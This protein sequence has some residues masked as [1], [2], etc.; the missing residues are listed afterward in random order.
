MVARYGRYF[1]ILFKEY[2]GI[3]QG[4][5]LPPT[6]FNMVVDAVTHHFVKV[7]APNADGLEG[8]DLPVRELEAYVY[9]D[10]GLV[11]R[12]SN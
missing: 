9:N 10:G 7:V 11:A 12:D 6:L 1:G 8:R 4:D 3:T 5:P 2:H